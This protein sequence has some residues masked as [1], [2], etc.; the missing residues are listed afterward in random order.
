MN[1]KVIEYRGIDSVVIAE[2]TNDDNEENGGYQFGDVM[3]LVPAAELTK[4]VETSTETHY[5]DNLAAIIIDA[6]GPDTVGITGAGM[7]LKTLALIAGRH[8]DETVGAMI[9]GERVTRYFALG[10][11]TKDTAGNY[12]YVWRFKGT[13]A[14]PEDSF[15]TIDNSTEARGTTLTYTGIHTIHQFT[16]GKRNGTAWEKGT[17]KAL[18]VDSGLGKADLTNF[19]ET[20]TTPDTLKAKAA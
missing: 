12:R 19:F 7:D 4:T 9:E 17:A 16:K 14:V 13:F 1:D 11:R 2:I 3:P 18:V 5:Y 20:V 10:Y 6:E 8:F 15:K